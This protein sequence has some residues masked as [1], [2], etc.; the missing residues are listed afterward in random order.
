MSHHKDGRE[1]LAELDAV[2]TEARAE[3][4]TLLDQIETLARARADLA[5][6]LNRTEPEAL[7]TVAEGEASGAVPV[8]AADPAAPGWRH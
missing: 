7:P 2:I 4:A 1:L 3:V 8:P 5:R 6:A